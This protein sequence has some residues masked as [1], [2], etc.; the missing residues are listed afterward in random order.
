MSIW[1]GTKERGR[2][3]DLFSPGGDDDEDDQ[4]LDPFQQDHQSIHQ[5]Y[6]WIRQRYPRRQSPEGHLRRGTSLRDPKA[7]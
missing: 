6:S 4:K 1:R 2:E 3:E 5:L 7:L